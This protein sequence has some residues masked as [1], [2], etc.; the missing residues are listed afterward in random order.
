MRRTVSIPALYSSWEVQA[1]SHQLAY[2]SHFTNSKALP[3]WESILKLL[4]RFTKH[5]AICS[6]R[7]KV[8]VLLSPN[9]TIDSLQVISD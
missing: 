5:P 6:L 3:A 9:T 7:Q 8:E 1:R 4:L 2:V